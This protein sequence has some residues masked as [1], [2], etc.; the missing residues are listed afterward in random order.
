MAKVEV[1]FLVE[2]SQ[3]IDWPD[4]EMDNFNYEN[5]QINCDPEQ[6]EIES[7]DYELKRVAVNGNEYEF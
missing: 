5:L 7:H 4:D 6:A 1:K 3:T 2:M